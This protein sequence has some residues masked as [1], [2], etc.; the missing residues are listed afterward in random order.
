[1]KAIVIEPN[2]DLVWKD[3]CDP[4]IADGEVLVEV[5]AAAVNRADLMQRAGTYPPPPGCPFRWAQ[6]PGASASG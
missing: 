1:M 5:H 4:V 3:V 2:K 6:T